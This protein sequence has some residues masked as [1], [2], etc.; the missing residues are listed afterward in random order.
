MSDD[1]VTATLDEYTPV[2]G[3]DEQ[4]RPHCPHCETRFHS[5]TRDR[6]T[7]IDR[8]GTSYPSI[9]ETDSTDGPFFCP[10]CWAKLETTRLAR[11]DDT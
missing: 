11:E 8:D 2:D 4:H 9:E 7:A 6:E 3:S 1:T 5:D 10:P